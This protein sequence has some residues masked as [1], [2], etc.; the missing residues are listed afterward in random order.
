LSEEPAIGQG[1]FGL[2]CLV[3]KHASVATWGTCI[4]R[5]KVWSIGTSKSQSDSHGIPP[6]FFFPPD[7]EQSMGE[8]SVPSVMADASGYSCVQPLRGSKIKNGIIIALDLLLLIVQKNPFTN[9]VK[10]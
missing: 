6:L 5:Q 10:S 8:K 3:I 4:S 9:P 1:F 2:I 7:F